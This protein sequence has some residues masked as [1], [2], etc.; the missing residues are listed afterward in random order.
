MQ[1]AVATDDSVTLGKV[2]GILTSALEMEP[3]SD[4][5]LVMTAMLRH[6]QADY[7]EEV[8]LYKSVL[9]RRPESYVVLMNLA[10]ALSEGLHLPEEAL[11]YMETLSKLA[12]GDIAVMDTHAVILMRLKRYDEAIRELRAV[13]D[14]KP[15]ALHYFHQALAY[16]R[17]GH[18]DEAQRCLDDARKAGLNVREVD[19]AER[20]D[21]RDLVEPVT[22]GQAK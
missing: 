3:N 11:P 13:V 7:K 16:K 8:R 15:S 9:T 22:V 10:W 5:L 2:A 21:F 17:G 18:A 4:E 14:A 20:D 19:V 1:V 6:L 12:G